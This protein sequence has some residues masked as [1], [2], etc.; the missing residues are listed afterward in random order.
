MCA[1][2]MKTAQDGAYSDSQPRPASLDQSDLC[3]PAQNI[4][5]G[6]DSDGLRNII[7]SYANRGRFRSEVERQRLVTNT[8][9]LAS[10]ASYEGR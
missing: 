2:I 3:E 1:A 6:R 8:M 5:N 7:Q 4:E 9:I 10:G